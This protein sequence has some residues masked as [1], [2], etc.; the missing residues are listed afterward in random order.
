MFLKR[1][2]RDN[3]Y[4]TSYVSFTIFSHAFS[5]LKGRSCHPEQTILVHCSSSGR[6]NVTRNA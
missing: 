3:L 6:G 5:S 2:D 1:V 4:N